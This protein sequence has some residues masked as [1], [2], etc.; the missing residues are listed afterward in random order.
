VQGFAQSDDLEG[1]FGQNY[2]RVVPT[3]AGQPDLIV[4]SGLENDRAAVAF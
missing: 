1:L 4:T 2:V 3:M